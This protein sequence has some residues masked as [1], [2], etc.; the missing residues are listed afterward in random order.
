MISQCDTS[1]NV[2]QDLQ[3]G[4]YWFYR[5]RHN[6]FDITSTD[7]FQYRSQFVDTNNIT[8]RDIFLIICTEYW[9]CNNLWIFYLLWN[10]LLIFYKVQ[11]STNH[12]KIILKLFVL[13]VAL[14]RTGTI[15]PGIREITP[16]KKW[17]KTYNFRIKWEFCK[18]SIK[19]R[20][21]LGFF[22]WYTII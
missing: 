7:N 9:Y 18:W 19:V 6:L 14:A 21:L 16:K 5:W 13:S 15:L 2:C 8:C 11:I 12:E 3:I 4:R 1:D 17:K 20:Y 22:S 10:Y